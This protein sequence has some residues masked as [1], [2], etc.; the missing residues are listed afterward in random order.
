ME[1]AAVVP[2]IAE[3]GLP[4]LVSGFSQCQDCRRDPHESQSEDPTPE[5]LD[6]EEVALRVG[7]DDPFTIAVAT[8]LHE[9]SSLARNLSDRSL[10]IH[11]GTVEVDPAGV[12][13]WPI[14]PLE[15]QGHSSLAGIDS[16][17]LVA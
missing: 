9:S 7:E 13:I 2:V 4:V 1:L 3:A 12:A 16:D 10:A 17:K 8:P 6:T 15:E 5:P 14:G 11:R